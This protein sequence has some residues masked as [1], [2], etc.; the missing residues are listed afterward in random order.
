MNATFRDCINQ[1]SHSILFT[2]KLTKSAS[3]RAQVPDLISTIRQPKSNAVT[4]TASAAKQPQSSDA[5]PKSK[6]T[7][8]AYRRSVSESSKRRIPIEK[9]SSSID[10]HVSKT[11]YHEVKSRYMEPKRHI[12]PLNNKDTLKIRARSSSGSSRTS[13]PMISSLIKDGHST[14]RKSMGGGDS[15]TMSRDSL[16]S[17]AKRGADKSF[18]SNR[19]ASRRGG[20][21]GG[22]HERLS[23]DS[24]GDSL[25]SSVI[26]NKTIS[27]ES[28]VRPTRESRSNAKNHCNDENDPTKKMMVKHSALS[29]GPATMV[30]GKSAQLKVCSA[31]ISQTSSTVN[32]STPSSMTVKSYLSSSNSINSPR[33]AVINRLTTPAHQI[34]LRRSAEPKPTVKSFLS[35]RSRQILAQKKTSLSHSDSSKSVPAIIRDTPPHVAPTGAVNKSNST[36][37]ILNQKVKNSPATP[38]L[39]RSTRLTTVQQPPLS[40]PPAQNIQKPTARSIPSLMNPTKSSSMKMSA[41]NH[42]KIARD[43]RIV[44][45]ERPAPVA[46]ERKQQKIT[47]DTAHSY[48]ANHQSS[49]EPDESDENTPKRRV[50]SKLERSSTFCKERS[51]IN[52]NELEVID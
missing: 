47:T 11:K 45:N 20:G 16:A 18:H 31:I 23:A 2:V 41:L 43:D 9:S 38:H 27:Q 37:N 14:N 49:N 52:T 19:S 32:S 5:K 39:K 25:H 1:F 22:D 12:E 40:L 3:A 34:P 48:N 7:I 44:D 50:E 17:P 35:A 6:P 8:P 13:S 42:Q 30:N 51:D 29:A 46:R 24:L 10:A 4:S 36:S 28:L 15:I 26:T 21:G 33:D